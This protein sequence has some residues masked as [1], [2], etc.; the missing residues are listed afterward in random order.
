MLD[1]GSTLRIVIPGPPCAQGRGR[2]YYN[3]H[4]G[5]AMVVDPVKSRSW[6]GA[7][8]VHYQEALARAG[9]SAP[10][11]PEGPVALDVVA[12]FTCPKSA[13]KRLSGSRR[14]KASR[15]DPDNLAKACLDAANGLLFTDDAQVAQLRVWK[16]IGY[17]GEAPYVEVTVRRL[18]ETPARV[19]ETKPPAGE[20]KG[21]FEETQN[22]R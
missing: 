9:A 1:S 3:R 21:L 5:R 19:R 11:I 12:V 10:L 17:A 18:D 6:K 15:P 13:P 7:A 16:L 22:C 4:L 20:T 2:A 8:Q 14:P